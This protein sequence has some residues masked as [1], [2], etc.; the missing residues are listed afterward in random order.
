MVIGQFGINL[1]DRPGEL[2]LLLRHFLGGIRIMEK[3]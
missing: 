1:A 3:V 2:S